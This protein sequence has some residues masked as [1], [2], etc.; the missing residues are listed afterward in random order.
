MNAPYKTGT[1]RELF[2]GCVSH[3]REYSAQWARRRDWV[4]GC[5]DL[6]ESPIERKL[7]IPMLFWD[8]FRVKVISPTPY[9]ST[10]TDRLDWRS[11]V[12]IEPQAKI[13]RHRVDFLIAPTTGEQD[14]KRLVIECDGHDYHERTKEQARKDRSRDRELTGLGY[15]VFRYTGSE[16]H[17]DPRRC[18]GDIEFVALQELANLEKRM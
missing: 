2:D 1:E 17:A 18:A 9:G 3:W 6:C 15:L 10:Y 7:L 13:G 4:F 8:Y 16:I 12:F 11:T 14:G 5:L